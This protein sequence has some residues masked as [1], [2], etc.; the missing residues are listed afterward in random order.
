MEGNCKGAIFRGNIEYVTKK[1]GKLGLEKLM[2][3]MKEKR[4]RLDLSNIID[5]NW[6]PMDARLQ[7]L[8]ST[9]ELFGLDEA[10]ILELGRSGF[11]QSAIIQIYLKVAGSPK[12]ICKF[13]PKVWSHNYDTGRL[14]A[15]YGGPEGTYFRI[16]DFKGVP[17]L[18]TYL[19]GFYTM[20]YE[21]V[22]AK[23]VIVDEPRCI[24]KGDEFHEFRI[25]WTA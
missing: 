20:A 17:L 12:K 3:D 9:V 6:Y 13:G 10:Q 19:I 16:Y 7:F 24:H 2:E 1:F 21:T 8:K 18:C 5:G 23:D 14:E 25:K 11:K 22:G 15:E 4:H